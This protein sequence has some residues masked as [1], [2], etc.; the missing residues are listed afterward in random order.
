[1]E[2]AQ[3]LC[4]AVAKLV[5][6]VS[7]FKLENQAMRLELN[8]LSMYKSKADC[9]A[10]SSSSYTSK[11]VSQTQ[12]RYPSKGSTSKGLSI[13]APSNSTHQ[14]VAVPIDRPEL[15]W[16]WPWAVG[17]CSRLGG[18]LFENKTKWKRGWKQVVWYQMLPYLKGG[19]V[20][21]FFYHT[22]SVAYH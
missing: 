6:E 17:S 2:M 9:S 22:L 5:N 1:M 3:S 18:Q 14:D 11:V 21:L 12:K 16:H 20:N 8:E 7:S 4:D 19:M 15:L 10:P 13:P